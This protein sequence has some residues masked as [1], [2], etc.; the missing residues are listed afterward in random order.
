ML[1]NSLIFLAIERE[2]IARRHQ[3]LQREIFGI[4]HVERIRLGD[5]TLGHIVGR[6]GDVLDLDAGI[7]QAFLRDLVACVHRGPEITQ[8]FRVG[9]VHIGKSGDGAR[10]CRQADRSG[11]ALQHGAT[12]DATIEFRRFAHDH[13]PKMSSRLFRRRDGYRTAGLQWACLRRVPGGENALADGV[14]GRV[15]LDLR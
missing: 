14:V 11:R 10:T 8:H 4:E 13:L 6:D 15:E 1:S 12:A 2:N 9:R 7:C 5:D 3:L